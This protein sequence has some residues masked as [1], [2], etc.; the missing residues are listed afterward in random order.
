MHNILLS[1][2]LPFYF[3]NTFI[4]LGAIF[5]TLNIYYHV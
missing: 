4:L 1:L 2:I 5:D 3:L